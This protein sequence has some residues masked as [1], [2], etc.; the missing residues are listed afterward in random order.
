MSARNLLSFSLVTVLIALGALSCG[1]SSLGTV[2]A[3]VQVQGINGYTDFVMPPGSN[4]FTADFTSSPSVVWGDI[5]AYSEGSLISTAQT[6]VDPAD[7]GSP[8]DGAHCFGDSGAIDMTTPGH[9]DV[10]IVCQWDTQAATVDVAVTFPTHPPTAN[11]ST[12]LGCPVASGWNYVITVT[13]VVNYSDLSGADD[14]NTDVRVSWL[15]SADSVIQ[16]PVD[17]TYSSSQD[18][19]QGGII[20]PTNG[21]TISLEVEDLTGG[22]ISDYRWPCQVQ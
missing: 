13:D 4:N 12:N 11:A 9:Y 6:S 8:P 22:G 19:W 7:A 15:D 18:Q 1:D 16:G 21:E 5:A 20:S 2:T 10:T 14:T 17:L 3:R